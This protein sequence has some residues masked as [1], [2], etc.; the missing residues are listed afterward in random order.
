MTG[1]AAVHIKAN[2]Q[3]VIYAIANPAIN[4][5]IVIINVGTFSPIAP[6]KAKVSVATFVANIFGLILSNQEISYFNKALK[7]SFLALIAYLSPVI[8]NVCIYNQLQM[9]EAPPKPINQNI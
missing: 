2:S 4:I 5:V 1:R 7:Y 3:P 8:I 6:Y 9:N